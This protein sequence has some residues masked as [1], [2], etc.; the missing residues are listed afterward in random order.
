MF[1]LSHFYRTVTIVGSTL[2]KH[3]GKYRVALS[4]INYDEPQ[5]F[6]I[7][8]RTT[9]KNTKVW[10]VAQNVTLESGTPQFIELD[11]G[12]CIVNL[13]YKIN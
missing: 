3:Q 7:A 6:E 12:I 9:N 2:L 5:V 13:D 11:V 10:Q 4:A 1:I 8:I